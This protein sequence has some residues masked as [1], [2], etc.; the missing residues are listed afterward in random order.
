[1]RRFDTILFDLDGTLTDNGEGITNSVAYALHKFGITPPPREELNKFIGPPLRD[2]FVN[3]YLG[4]ERGDLA[5]EYYREYYRPHGIFENE[6]YDGIPETLAA[7][8]AAGCTLAIATSKPEVFAKKIA[9]H[10]DLAKYFTV[11]AGSTLDGSLIKKG[12]VIEYCLRKLGNPDRSRTVMVGDREHDIFGAAQAGL[13]GIGVTYGYGSR[14]ELTA[15]HALA[16]ID[17]P[18]ELLNHI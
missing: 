18:Q 15:A 1:M 16:V 6:V 12:D 4:E 2:C 14:E 9:D 10:F 11:I 3:W 17:S 13:P 8:K 7:L 5:V